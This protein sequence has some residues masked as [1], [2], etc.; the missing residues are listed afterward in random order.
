MACSFETVPAAGPPGTEQ[1]RKPT[2]VY[3]PRGTNSNTG[4]PGGTG[5]TDGGVAGCGSNLTGVVRDFK[6][7]HADM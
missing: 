2:V 7:A 3:P 5:T 4:T 6:Q 1:N